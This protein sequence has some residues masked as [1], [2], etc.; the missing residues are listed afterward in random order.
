MSDALL[1]P[2]LLDYFAVI[3]RKESISD[4]G[5]AVISAQT[6]PR[7]FGNV[8]AASP[9][10]LERLG[11]YQFQGA[12]L[13]IVTRFKFYAE[14]E[15]ALLQD[16]QPD[17]IYWDSAYYI[18]K[19]LENYSRYG[20]GFVQAICIETTYVAEPTPQGAVFPTCDF[21]NPQNSGYLPCF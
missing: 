7:I 21:S 14:S 2:M 12:A 5:R 4:H 9:N 20:P 11:D 3:R 16:Y 19:T 15:T 17:L 10:D 8:N 1:D 6:L 18:V 13:S